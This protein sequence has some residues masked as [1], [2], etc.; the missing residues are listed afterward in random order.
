MWGV[1]IYFKTAVLLVGIFGPLILHASGEHQLYVLLAQ[2]TATYPS[3]EAGRLEEQAAALDVKTSRWRRYPNVSYFA[4][5]RLEGKTQIVTSVDQPLLVFGRLKNEIDAA[6]AVR[7]AKRFSVSEAELQVMLD[8]TDAYFA[9]F[10]ANE[11]HRMAR[12]NVG[13]HERLLAIINRRVDAE[14]SAQADQ[15]LAKARLQ[16]AI[17]E[18]INLENEVVLSRSRVRQYVPEYDNDPEG[19]LDPVLAFH[20]VEALLAAAETYSPTL[21][22]LAA[23][24]DQLQAQRRSAESELFPSFSLGYEKRKGSFQFFGPRNE[25]HVFLSMKYETGA[26]LSKRSSIQAAKQRVLSSEQRQRSASREISNQVQAYWASYEAAR[27]QKITLQELVGA[28]EAVVESY[29]RQYTVGR[30]SWLDVM[31]AQREWSSARLS[32]MG[33]NANYQASVVRL[34]LITGGLTKAHFETAYE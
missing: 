9:L 3:I 28:T 2:A 13:E 10:A 5:D 1:Q 11:K 15:M 32:Q 23:N 30:K 31:N 4:D 19:L 7:N 14:A 29:L 17:S 12:E 26:G 21:E 24:E 34:N 33:N 6:I 8:V 27:L 16:F 18:Q 25:E 22:R 20:G